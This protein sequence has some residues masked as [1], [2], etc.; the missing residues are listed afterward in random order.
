MKVSV[1]CSL[2]HLCE[3]KACY[4]YYIYYIWYLN[5]RHWDSVQRWGECLLS[6][7]AKG[8]VPVSAD[9]LCLVAFICDHVDCCPPGSSVRGD[10]PGKNTGVGCHALLQGIFSTQGSNPGIPHCRQILHCPSH[11]WRGVAQGRGERGEEEPRLESGNEYIC[12]SIHS[13][14][15]CW[16]KLKEEGERVRRKYKQREFSRY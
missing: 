8:P 10:S 3:S 11:Q 7:R 15:G 6:V 5:R 4:H 12:I 14:S 2:G 16:Y 13:C 9:V 1:L